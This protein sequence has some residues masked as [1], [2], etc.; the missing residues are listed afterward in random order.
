MWQTGEGT[1]P[2]W[3]AT[4]ISLSLRLIVMSGVFTALNSPRVRTAEYVILVRKTSLGPIHIGGE[5][6]SLTG[7]NCYDFDT[8][9][10]STVE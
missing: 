5:L 1:P 9:R 4:I 7:S 8:K 3:M 6:V 10:V 2:T